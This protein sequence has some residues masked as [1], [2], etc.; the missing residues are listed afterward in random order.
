MKKVAIIFAAPSPYRINL[1]N[2]LLDNYS[3]KYEFTFLFATRPKD[4]GRQW[5]IDEDALRNTEFLKSKKLKISIG[6]YNKNTNFPIKIFSTLNRINPDI[7]IGS[8]YSPSIVLSY[9]WAKLNKKKYISWSDGILHTERNINIIQK[10]LRKQICKNSDALISSSSETKKAQIS[11]GAKEDKIFISY[12]T[13][14]IN[15]YLIPDHYYKEQNNNFLFVGRLLKL[16]GVDL[17]LKAL[18]TIEEDYKLFI[19]GDGEEKQNLECL[20]EELNIKNK[21]EF[22][23]YL[24][25]EKLVNYYRKCST[26]I[27]PSLDDCFGLV[28][29]EAICSK[30]ALIGSKYSGATH[31]IIVEGENGIIIDPYNINDTAIKL[32][33]FINNK[34]MISYYQSNSQINLNKFTFANVA[35]ELIN[36]LN[37]VGDIH[38]Q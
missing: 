33:N 2:Y 24:E 8:E 32:K 14:D 7:I 26:F 3:E 11:Y 27:F 28:L 17:I 38:E 16:K 30:M 15:K 5:T 1:F 18:S 29:L 36:A 10:I 9:F 6:K 37:Y 22:L 31:D 23:G 34:K 4:F 13:V 20:C 19:I 35:G 25:G 21:V 12:L